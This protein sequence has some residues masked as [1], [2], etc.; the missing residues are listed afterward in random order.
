M[1][2]RGHS[3]V[4]P[5]LNG[6]DRDAVSTVKLTPME[7]SPFANPTDF[8][9]A[10]HRTPYRPTRV[11]KGVQRLTVELTKYCEVGCSFCKYCA[12][13]PKSG[14]KDPRLYLGAEAI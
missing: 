3:N 4:I 9:A 12:P 13:Y 6:S 10:L 1:F 8:I 14:P 7:Q 2:L 11:P 5:E